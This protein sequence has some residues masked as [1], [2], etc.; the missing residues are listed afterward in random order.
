MYNN[1][2]MCFLF[3]FLNIVS[4]GPI[5]FKVGGFLWLFFFFFFAVFQP[6]LVFGADRNFL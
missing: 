6:E 2:S 4:F 5:F 3:I 1:F